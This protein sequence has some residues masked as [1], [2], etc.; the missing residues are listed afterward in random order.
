MLLEIERFVRAHPQIGW[1]AVGYGIANLVLWIYILRIRLWF[2]NWLRRRLRSSPQDPQLRIV[3]LRVRRMMIRLSQT[4]ENRRRWHYPFYR[5][6]N[7]ICFYA[8]IGWILWVS[9]R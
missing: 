7:A 1:M 4:L 2:A 3:L 9:F 8:I 5:V 6:L